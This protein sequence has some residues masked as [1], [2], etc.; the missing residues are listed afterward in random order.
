MKKLIKFIKPL[1]YLITLVTSILLFIKYL[2]NISNSSFAV[3]LHVWFGLI[4]LISIT[5]KLGN[6]L[7]L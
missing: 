7:K 6:N 1:P 5:Q 3:H 2:I 4:F